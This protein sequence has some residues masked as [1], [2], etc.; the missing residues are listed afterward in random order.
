[1]KDRLLTRRSAE[2]CT[3]NTS[4]LTPVLTISHFFVCLRTRVRM[5]TLAPEVSGGVEL[6]REL[7]ARGWVISIGHTRAD[8]KVLD[9]A[10]D[11]GAR[12]MTH[13]MNAMSPLHHRTSWT[14]RLGIVA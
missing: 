8:L 3:R 4:R 2:R 13:F 10:C 5:I 12:H 14:N 11:A 6:V 1:M 9:E 7:K